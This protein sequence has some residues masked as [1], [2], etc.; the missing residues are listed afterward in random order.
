MISRVSNV[1]WS[2]RSLVRAAAG[3]ATF[4]SKAFT[5]SNGPEQ[6]YSSAELNERSKRLLETELTNPTF[7]GRLQQSSVLGLMRTEGVTRDDLMMK[8]LPVAKSFAHPPLSNFFVGAVALGRTG[9]MYLGANIEIPR[10]MLG[11]TVH[12]EQSAVANAYMSGETGLEAI[13]V[14]A[15][16]CGHCRQFLS[17]LSVVPSLRVLVKDTPVALLSDLLPHPFG[18]KDLGF[19]QGAL[20]VRRTPLKLASH[21][22]DPLALS[23]FSAACTSYSPYTKSPSGVAVL[24]SSGRTFEGSYIEN[25]AFNPSLPP[26]EVCMCGVFAAG[27]SADTVTRAVLVE[28]VQNTVSQKNETHEALAALCPSARFDFAYA[29]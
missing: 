4:V 26:F 14:T 7:R 23:A 28:R 9:S 27:M 10:N 22:E 18:P 1:R 12:A 13:A 8:L 25:A 16:P 6:L 24:T 19:K 11:F 20:P 15:P 17:E 3:Y 29:E 2:R 5:L 21:S